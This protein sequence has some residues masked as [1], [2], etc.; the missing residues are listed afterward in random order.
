MAADSSLLDSSEVVARCAIF[1]Q[2]SSN[3]IR[4]SFAYDKLLYFREPKVKTTPKTWLLSVGWRAKLT[5]ETDVHAYGCRTAAN[6]NGRKAEEANAKGEAVVPLQDTV[7]YLGYY[8]IAVAAAIAATN[9][10]YE[11]YA[12][13][14]PELGENAHSHIVFR[15]RA[16]LEKNPPKSARRTVIVD[17][18]WRKAA[19]PQKHIC[20]CDEA[21]RVFLEGIPL[22]APPV[23]DGSVTPG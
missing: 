7:H 18:L 12:E 15:E 1:P 11:V 6:S 13:N 9:D 8:D 10:V 3:G 16:K 23:E 22:D 20:G 17:A 5:S 19:G 21:H 2:F 14:A 4:E